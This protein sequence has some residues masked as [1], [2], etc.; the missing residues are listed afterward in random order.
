[1]NHITEALDLIM[2]NWLVALLCVAVV[3]L[4]AGIALMVGYERAENKAAWQL[5]RSANR[6]A[7]AIEA[8]RKLYEQATRN[9][10]D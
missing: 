3:I 4:I 1:V 5:A 8:G 6:E 9:R 2:Q 7:K 10:E